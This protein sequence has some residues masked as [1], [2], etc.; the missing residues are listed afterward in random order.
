MAY[1]TLEDD[2]GTMELLAFQR[3]LDASMRYLQDNAAIWV[4]GKISVRDDTPQILVDKIKPLAEMETAKQKRTVYIRLE[5]ESD[6]RL[7]KTMA[8][9]NMFPGTDR[10]VL[11]FRDTRRQQ[12]MYCGIKD[13]LVDQLNEWYTDGDVVVK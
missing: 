3:V 9:V 1:I 12:G 8:A 13:M 7:R 6:P 11:F 5:S 10:A 2:T 4:S